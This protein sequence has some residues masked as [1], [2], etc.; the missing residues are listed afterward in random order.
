MCRPRELVCHRPEGFQG[1][2]IN[3]LDFHATKLSS[4]W[5]DTRHINYL[6]TCV[7]ICPH[8][9]ALHVCGFFFNEGVFCFVGT[10]SCF[11]YPTSRWFLF[12]ILYANRRIA[13]SILNM[14]ERCMG[15]GFVFM[16]MNPC[17]H[18]TKIFITWNHHV[19]VWGQF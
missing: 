18:F 12:R 3:V 2:K 17:S 15:L 8:S 16:K 10:V 6:G 4:T 14:P 9:H 1:E 5:C 11:N 13:F 19:S 7:K